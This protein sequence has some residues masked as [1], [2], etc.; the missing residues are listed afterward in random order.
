MNYGYAAAP[1]LF[2]QLEKTLK[3]SRKTKGR[4][5]LNLGVFSIFSF[6]LHNVFYLGMSFFPS[7]EAH[8]SLQ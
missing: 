3:I 4:K 2:G 6:E 8:A 7:R 5:A 1:F